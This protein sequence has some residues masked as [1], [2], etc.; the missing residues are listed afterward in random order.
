MYIYHKNKGSVF[1]VLYSKDLK[2]QSL[3]FDYFGS[4]YTA[5]SLSGPSLKLASQAVVL[6]LTGKAP[7]ETPFLAP[8]P[9]RPL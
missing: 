8:V 5:S 1:P 6:L 2:Q 9:Q 3:L 7:V 4:E